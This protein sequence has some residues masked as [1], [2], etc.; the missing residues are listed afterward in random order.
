M[1][2]VAMGR[3]RVDLVGGHGAWVWVRIWIIALL[4][5]GLWGVFG[6]VEGDVFDHGRSYSFGLLHIEMSPCSIVDR[7]ASA[8]KFSFPRV[9]R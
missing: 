3:V 7:V 4:Y 8:S 5:R 1:P 2:V 6:R 9:R